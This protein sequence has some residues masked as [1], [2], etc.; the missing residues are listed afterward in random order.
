MGHGSGDGS[1]PSA[2]VDSDTARLA[3]QL[4]AQAQTIDE[5]R[6]TIRQLELALHSRVAIE[7]ATGILAE[8]FDLTVR[9]AFDLLRAAA[10][11]SRQ[12]LATLAA[13]VVGAPGWTPDEI[14]DERRRHETP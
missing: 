3:V 9:E 4:T 10:R 8:R 12:L 14:I 5:L 7:R 2:H 1:S 11:S 6:T 13:D